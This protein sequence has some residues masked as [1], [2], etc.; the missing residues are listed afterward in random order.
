VEREQPGRKVVAG[1]EGTGSRGAGSP[2]ADSEGVGSSVVGG[3][4]RELGEVSTATVRWLGG[5]HG[6][7]SSW[8]PGVWEPNVGRCRIRSGVR[9]VVWSADAQDGCGRWHRMATTDEQ[10]WRW[11]MGGHARRFEK[12]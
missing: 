8:G 4:Q 6:V 3:R 5:G 10:W 11:C 12:I 1:L 2:V 9:R 7:G